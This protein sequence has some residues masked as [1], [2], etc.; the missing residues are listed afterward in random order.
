MLSTTASFEEN[1]DTEIKK[2][3]LFLKIL[4]LSIMYRGMSKMSHHTLTLQKH[5]CSYITF[6]ITFTFV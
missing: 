2:I 3:R 1:K 5:V 6:Y 4:N